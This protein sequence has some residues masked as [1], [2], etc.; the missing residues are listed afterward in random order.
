MSIKIERNVPMP[1]TRTNNKYPW[2]KMKVGD[3]F[4]TDIEARS[5]YPTAI[6]AG[7]KL[8]KK[9]VVRTSDKG[10]RVWRTE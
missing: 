4:E 7:A 2:D 8:G 10:C 1:E 5:M 6:R 3:S 9:F